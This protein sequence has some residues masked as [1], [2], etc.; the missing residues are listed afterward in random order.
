MPPD[1]CI[2]VPAVVPAVSDTEIGGSISSIDGFG[3]LITTIDADLLS[4]F[5]AFPRLTI[6]VKSHLLTLSQGSY[7]HLPDN[8]P[9]A[10]INSSNLLEICVKNGNAAAL[11]EVGIGEKVAVR[12]RKGYPGSAPE[13]HQGMA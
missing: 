13:Q 8:R 3:N 1:S 10:L 6:R 12:R 9:A 7:G 11:L 5:S 2:T 4:S